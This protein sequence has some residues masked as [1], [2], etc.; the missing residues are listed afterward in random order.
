MSKGERVPTPRVEAR[1]V[2]VV[3]DNVL[4]TTSVAD[5]GDGQV[6]IEFAGLCDGC[7]DSSRDA[8]IDHGY[9]ERRLAAYRKKKGL[10]LHVNYGD[11]VIPFTSEQR[12]RGSSRPKPV[13]T[14]TKGSSRSRARE[15]RHA[16]NTGADRR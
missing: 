13:P 5:R 15:R 3:C 12:G 11:G 7:E 4:L 2:C 8:C 1:L 6:C 10:A 14:S 9:I 16:R